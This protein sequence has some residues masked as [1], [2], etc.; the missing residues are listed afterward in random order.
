LR[1]RSKKVTA[2]V[3]GRPSGTAP[4]PASRTPVPALSD[5][6]PSFRKNGAV[7]PLSGVARV[8]ESS[9]PRDAELG[10]PWSNGCA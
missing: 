10:A 4:K 6:T 1:F 2:V 9:K 3:V 5:G 8:A 7:M